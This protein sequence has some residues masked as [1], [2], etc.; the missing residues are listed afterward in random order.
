MKRI[1][2]K[3]LRLRFGF[4][5]IPVD[6]L[7]IILFIIALIVM[8]IGMLGVIL[9]VLPGVPLIFAAALL[10]DLL[11][12]FQFLGARPLIIMGILALITQILDW[13]ASVYGVK[14]MGGTKAGMIGAFVGMIAGLLIPGIGI[15]GFVIGSFVG[16]FLFEFAANREARAA[17]RAGLGSFLGFL[18][19]GVVKFVIGAII[20]GMFI[21]HVVIK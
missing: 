3:L 18:A 8:L 9:P 21:W 1:R 16:A 2:I 20:I 12:G 15:F 4:I 5:N 10:F 11:S 6:W 14:R 13:V 7:E 19:G 17:W